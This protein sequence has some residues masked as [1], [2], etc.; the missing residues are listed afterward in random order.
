MTTTKCVCR[1]LYA[2]GKASV[3]NNSSLA[4][5]DFIVTRF[6]IKLLTNRKET[7]KA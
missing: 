4:L 6:F 7:I 2:Y 1:L 3:L 5:F